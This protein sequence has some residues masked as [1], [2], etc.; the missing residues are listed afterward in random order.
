[1]LPANEV[2]TRT[3]AAN[4]ERVAESIRLGSTGKVDAVFNTEY[5]QDREAL[6]EALSLSIQ[7]GRTPKGCF[8]SISSKIF[9]RNQKSLALMLMVKRAWEVV[10]PTHLLATQGRFDKSGFSFDT[11]IQTIYAFLYLLASG[12]KAPEVTNTIADYAYA[13]G[14]LGL[15]YWRDDVIEGK[16]FLS[17]NPLLALTI[18][19]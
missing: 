10:L 17:L 4:A 16:R 7:N 18:T 11:N 12:A 3:I 15:K 6:I 1:M 2:A 8:K 13:V 9:S 14:G 5:S 19:V